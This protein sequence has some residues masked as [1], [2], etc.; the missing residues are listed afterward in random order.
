MT[1]DA[2]LPDF[3]SWDQDCYSTA[4]ASLPPGYKGSDRGDDVGTSGSNVVLPRLVYST[5]TKCSDKHV[6]LAHPNSSAADEA[7]DERW[8]RAKEDAANAF[9]LGKISFEEMQRR[10]DSAYTKRQKAMDD[11]RVAAFRSEQAPLFPGPWPTSA[12][13]SGGWSRTVSEFCTS[14]TRTYAGW[15]RCYD[16]VIDRELAREYPDFSW[17]MNAHLSRVEA[18]L[19]RYADGGITVR[20]LAAEIDGADAQE[21]EDRVKAL[22]ELRTGAQPPPMP[23]PTVDQT[24]DIF[25]PGAFG[26]AL[27]AQ[28]SIRCH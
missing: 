21:H 16:P 10:M 14:H 27:G 11:A 3:G 25:G 13:T 7:I 5:Y 22:A 23:P 26:N 17:V 28:G 15:L 19:E 2:N 8:Y 18:A 1:S 24:C 4:M 20:E 12:E 6:R 9:S